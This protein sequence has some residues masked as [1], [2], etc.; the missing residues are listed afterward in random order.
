MRKRLC[1]LVLAVMVMLTG[2][3]SSVPDLSRLHNS[4]EAEYMAGALLKYSKN[5]D[6]MLDYDRSILTATPTPEPTKT[7]APRSSDDA[8][9]SSTDNA[10]PSVQGDEPVNFVELDQI[11]PKQG[12]RMDYVN[13]E[14]KKTY[15]SRDAAVS[16]HDGNHLLIV[17][18]RLKNEDASDKS[19][20]MMKAGMNFSLELDGASAGSPLQTILGNDLQYF[21][22][23]IPGGKS[24]EAVLVFEIRGKKSVGEASVLI[25]DGKKTARISLQ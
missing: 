5:Y 21:R 15:G 1:G 23:K 2:C 25:S 4:M 3:A 22:E 9:Q 12:I 11:S 7:P 19:I 14:Q 20:D 13:Y 17:R 10:D 6:E 8:G 18:F 16:A 24:R